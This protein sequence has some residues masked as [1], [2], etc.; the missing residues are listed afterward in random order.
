M[1]LIAEALRKSEAERRRGQVPSLVSLEDWTPRPRARESRRGVAFVAGVGVALLAMAGA[2]WWFL[3]GVR[4]RLAGSPSATAPAAEIAS[5]P[6]P[7]IAP[8]PAA[9]PATTSAP[10]PTVD[11]R[12]SDRVTS[13][14]VTPSAPVPVE[15]LA[16]APS[17]PSPTPLAATTAGS[18]SIASQ[19]ANAPAATASEPPFRSP[20]PPPAFERSSTPDS[21]PPPPPTAPS[22]STPIASVP[23]APV[24]ATEHVPLL[25]ELPDTQRAALPALK[26]DMHVYSK[27]PANRFVLVNGKRLAEGEGGDGVRVVEI[28]PD[29]VVVDAKSVR[30][31]LPRG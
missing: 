4:E 1:S 16:P 5:A 12:P 17:R 19:P 30:V 2:A 20:A 6:K 14:N 9:T 8:S 31:F 25:A 23:A 10:L 27:D 29:G 26:L 3:P 28:R 24:V 18:G 21:A 22:P 11:A 13:V 7:A 15:P